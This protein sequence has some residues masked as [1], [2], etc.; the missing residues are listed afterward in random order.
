MDHYNTDC[1]H[2]GTEILREQFAIWKQIGDICSKNICQIPSFSP[3]DK[4][5][6]KKKKILCVL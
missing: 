4:K 5:K 1:I 6:K 3:G 2:K